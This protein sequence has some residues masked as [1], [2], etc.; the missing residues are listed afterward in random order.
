MHLCCFLTF[1]WYRIL[2]RDI[3]PKTFFYN[4]CLHTAG[5]RVVEHCGKNGSYGKCESCEPETY[6]SEPND[7]MSCERCTSCSQENGTNAMGY[8]N[9]SD[10]Q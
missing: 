8:H 2:L 7:Q 1:P 6:S 5:L 4:L 3:A 9:F 10:V